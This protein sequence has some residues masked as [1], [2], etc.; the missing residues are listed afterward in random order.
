MCAI[1]SVLG[2]V[3]PTGGLLIPARLVKGIAAGFPPRSR[4]WCFR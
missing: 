3:A 1:V 2:P 4:P